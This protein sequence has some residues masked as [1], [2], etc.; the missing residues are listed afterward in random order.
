MRSVRDHACG[1]TAGRCIRV[2]L[3]ATALASLKPAMG[4]GASVTIEWDA[5]RDTVT[6]GYYVYYGTESGKYSGNV[7]VG[8]STSA[9]INPSDS[10]ATYYFAVQAYSASG[11]RSP[12]SSELVWKTGASAH[13]PMLRNPGSMSTIVGQSVN[14]QLSATD[15][16][17]LAQSYSAV[18]L[19]P[20]LAL[21]TSSG[22]IFGTPN[23]A[24]V[25][26]V[27]ATVT[28]TNGLSAAQR[29]TWTIL[30]QPSAPGGGGGSAPGGGGTAAGNGTG[31]GSAV[32]PIAGGG[33][34]GGEDGG[35]TVTNPTPAADRIPPAI[36]IVSPA[37]AGGSYQT[38]NMRVIVTGVASDNVGIASVTWA[39]SRVG[40]G[41]AF[42]TS[43]WATGPID[44]KLG[45]N[46]ITITAA[47]TAGNVQTAT[48]TVTRIVDLR[49]HLN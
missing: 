36:N 1:R 10:A 48:L 47:D 23:A 49:N 33:G 16:G 39:N 4:Y 18:G 43:S 8:K 7:D 2:V 5:N 20:A 21:R 13:S 41:S 34:T 12:L 22:S 9:I 29:F 42:G 40:D 27:T 26:N 28:N 44:L 31:G 3:F 37:P 6:A 15:A 14:V 30:S 32:T 17:G 38:I 11:E 19:P 25:Y 45:D 35:G 46:V 24:G